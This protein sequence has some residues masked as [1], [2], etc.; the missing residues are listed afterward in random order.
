MLRFPII[1]LQLQVCVVDTRPPH[2]DILTCPTVHYTN[3]RDSTLIPTECVPVERACGIRA[4]YSTLSP[5]Q[6]P[7][8]PSLITQYPIP[9]PTLP[10]NSDIALMMLSRLQPCAL[11]R[12]AA[13]SF[14]SQQQ[15]VSFPS[16]RVNPQTTSL[17]INN[18]N[19]NHN[20]YLSHRSFAGQPLGSIFRD[21][22]AIPHGEFLDKYCV[23]LTLL[24]ENGKVGRS[25]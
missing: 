15:L 13:R 25:T 22:S 9:T 4:C 1:S 21:A 18:N 17:L 16:S 23:D 24:A 8:S 5:L 7:G 3:C 14:F 12:L 6:T 19:T 2:T 20:N 11:H 10:P